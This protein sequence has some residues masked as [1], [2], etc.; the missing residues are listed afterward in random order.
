MIRRIK[1]I[2]ATIAL[3]I[4]ML[5]VANTSAVPDTRP[6]TTS[7]ATIYPEDPDHLVVSLIVNTSTLGLESLDGSFPLTETVTI[8]GGKTYY[9]LDS[10]EPGPKLEAWGGAIVVNDK[11][12]GL[13]AAATASAGTY[14]PLQLEDVIWT[15]KYKIIDTEPIPPDVYNF[16]LIVNSAVFDTLPALS[17]E[18]FVFGTIVVPPKHD[19]PVIEGDNGIYITGSGAKYI[20]KLD[21]DHTYL[22]EILMDGV[23][24]ASSNYEVKAGST[25]IEFAADYLNTLGLGSHTITANF[26]DGG[27]GVAHFT[28]EAAPSPVDPTEPTSDETVT[29]PDTGYFTGVAGSATAIGA[30][31][32]MGIAMIPVIIAVS[33][34]RRY[35]RN[36]IDFTKK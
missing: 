19:V 32:F 14:I 11:N 16:T 1:I 30:G 22:T 5:P 3:A 33:I 36:K 12:T 18:A 21:A 27:V 25:I 7:M 10:M 23:V 24:V 26:S 9:K 20:L 29:V 34:E 2:I 8:P 15:A 6:I 13:F 35:S 31:I 28:I 4:V 17:N